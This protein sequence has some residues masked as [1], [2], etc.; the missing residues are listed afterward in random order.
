MQTNFLI[1]YDKML[2]KMVSVRSCGSLSLHL[3]WNGNSSDV[4]AQF[5]SQQKLTAPSENRRKNGGHLT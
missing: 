5:T 1:K 3:S 2:N 4:V